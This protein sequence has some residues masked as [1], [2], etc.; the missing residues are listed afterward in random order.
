[1]IAGGIPSD[2]ITL[3]RDKP[4]IAITGREPPMNRPPELNRHLVLLYSGNYGVP[5]EIDTVVDGLIR[6]CREGSGRFALWLN[7]SGSNADIV[8]KRLRKAGVPIARTQPVALQ[9]LPSLLAAADVHLITL[10]PR[11]SGLVLPS[12]IYACLSSQKPILFVG[13]EDSDVHL[14]CTQTK[15]LSYE[16]IEPGD[17]VG[18]CAAL[19]RITRSLE[20]TA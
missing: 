10:R 16:R 8:E 2:R 15:D 12:K 14:L 9:D 3:K 18:F 6:D 1:M 19:N 7:A 13:P 20:T 11:F 17:V 5:H 4:P